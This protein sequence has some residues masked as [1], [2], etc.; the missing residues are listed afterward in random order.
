MLDEFQ[1]PAKPAANATA[2][3][4]VAPSAAKAEEG[5]VPKADD[6]LSDDFVQELTKNM[7][8]F[9]AQL[10]QHMP[11]TGAPPASGSGA[12]ATNGQSE[13]ELVR[14]FE[15][16]L[17][18]DAGAAQSA[19]KEAKPNEARAPSA[20][21]DDFQGAIQ[22]T[23]DKL[24]Q[25]K[26]STKQANAGGANPLGGLGLDENM[27]MS[28]LLAAL[29]G[30]GGEGEG[31]GQVPDLANLLGSMMENLMSKDI[32]YEPLKDMH[33]KFPEY[34]AS[35]KGKKL[36]GDL[37]SRYK[38][39]QEIIGQVLAEFESPSYDV[40]DAATKKRI[41]DLVTRMQDLGTPPEELLGEMPAE[42]AGLNSMMG[43][44][45]PDENCVVM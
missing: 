43:Q 45:G 22:A 9:M 33:K 29:G 21:A 34:L 7:E 23:I 42:F 28:Q 16:M 32:L 19:A 25:S 37:R 2:A 24:K 35:E 20:S 39:Q 36:D 38:E 14:Q 8:S 27:D 30:A 4:E 10:G 11:A 44:G 5:D 40:N 6:P 1:Q 18:G 12:D 41:S 13:E 17:A 26:E 31:D 3:A 15:R